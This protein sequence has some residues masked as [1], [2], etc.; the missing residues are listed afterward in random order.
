MLAVLIKFG[1]NPSQARTDA[2]LY[3]LIF[4]LIGIGAFVFSFLQQTLF[5]YIG[6][7]LT[8]RVRNETYYKIL[9]MPGAWFDKPKNS[10]G[11]LS[12]RLASDCSTVNGLMTTFISSFIQ[13]LTT[14]ISGI[15]IAFVY[16][17]RTSLVALG[18]LP[19]MIISGAVQMA[20]TEGFSDKTDKA[21]KDSANLI[22]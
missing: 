2:N 18:M 3:A 21:Y 11:A 10:S 8:E 14:L 4:L 9:K 12:A 1:T 13:S 19:L 20:F 15:V 22:T 7:S 17:W 6:E 5:S 16:E